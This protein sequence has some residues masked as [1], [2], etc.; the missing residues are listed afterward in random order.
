M[1]YAPPPIPSMLG[2]IYNEE[3]VKIVGLN[4]WAAYKGTQ[5]IH[6]TKT[7]RY[8]VRGPY[9]ETHEG[10]WIR[11]ECSSSWHDT[12]VWCSWEPQWHDN[13]CPICHEQIAE[14]DLLKLISFARAINV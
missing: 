8:P 7:K 11:H 14:I 10:K 6:R 5:I 2:G 4:G 9:Q 12:T 3:R 1:G 13:K